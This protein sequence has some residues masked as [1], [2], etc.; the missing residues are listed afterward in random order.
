MQIN[1]KPITITIDGPAG[2][3]KTTTAQRVA[4]KLGYLHLD[5][6]ALYRAATLKAL[7][8]NV[9]LDDS[10]AVCRLVE[11]SD[12]ELVQNSDHL[13]VLLDG[14]DVTQEIRSPRVTQSISKVASNPKVRAVLTRIQREIASRYGVV[15]EGR[16][17][18][19]VVFPDAELK[20]YMIASLDQRVKRRQAELEEKGMHIDGDEL[21]RQIEE[22]DR[23]D[24][25]R[26]HS[27]LV[28]PQDAIDIDTSK[29]SI[30]EQVDIIVREA[31]KRG[32][33]PK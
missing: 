19:S 32:A 1:K 25:Q 24:Q 21:R 16:D 18:G 3:G 12:F 23:S 11:N 15:A 8:R 26:T 10:S 28:R 9:S 31:I 20:I 22:R 4:K 17:T 33:V 5:S 13:K 27:P 2:S 6:G 7:N 30:D 14:K 29:L